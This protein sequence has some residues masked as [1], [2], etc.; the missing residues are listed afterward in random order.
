MKS[1]WNDKE[2]VNWYNTHLQFAPEDIKEYV[3]S[4]RLGPDESLADFGCGNGDMLFHVA[5]MVNFAMGVDESAPQLE[6]ARAKNAANKNIVFTQCRLQEC[7]L[8]GNIFTR[9]SARKSLHHLTDAEKPLFFKH[10]GPSFDPGAIFVIEDMVFDFPRRELEQ[11]MPRILADAQKLYGARWADIKE[12]FLH[13]VHQE[14]PTGFDTWEQ[15][16]NAG[17]FKVTEC[18]Q[19]NC[20]YGKITAVK[21]KR[22]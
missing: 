11:N 5:A 6:Q 22:K 9:G 19:P 13:T 20:F 4:L 2:L 12:A 10:I 7:N 16:L 18:W 1:N 14:E 3:K 8:G 15:A 21:E 17:G